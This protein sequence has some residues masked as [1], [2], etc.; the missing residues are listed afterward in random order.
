MAGEN[1]KTCRQ[2]TASVTSTAGGKDVAIEETMVTALYDERNMSLVEDFLFWKKAIAFSFFISLAVIMEGYDTSLMNNFFPFPAFKNKFGDEVDPDGGRL[3]SARWQTIILNGT[4]VGCIIG[5]AINGYLSEWLGYK[6]T[7]VATMMAMVAAIFIP[8]F[9]TS[10]DMYLIGGIIQGLPWGVF[11]TLAVSYAADLCPTH[12][13]AYMTSWVN[14]CWV[15]GGLLSTGILRGLLNIDSEWGYRI[16]FALQWLWPIPVTIATL[17]C[18]ESPWW[19][20]RKG[21]IDE[22]KAAIRM[23]TS[24]R[25]GSMDFDVDSHVEM[26]IVTDKF[27]RQ[28]QA[29]TNYWH[30]FQKS[31]LRRTEIAAMVCITQAFCGVPFMGYGVQF[32]VRAGLD[33][34]SA[35]NLNVVQSCVGLIGCILAWWLMTYFGRRFLY[36]S[37]LSSMFVILMAI[38]F[39]GL[40]PDSNAGTSWAV[41]A[42]IIFMLFLFQ[43][44]LGPICYAVFAEIASTRLRIKTVVIARASYNSAVFVNNAIMPRIVGRNDWDW[45]AKGGFFWAGIDL[46][47]LFWTWFRL[48][49]S[50]GLTYAELDLLFEHEVPARHFSQERADM[51]KPALDEIAAKEKRHSRIQTVEITI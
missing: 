19:L 46:L 36:L 25:P 13:R 1:V 22:A 8:F 5:L 6:K 2:T 10:L 16:P 40:A 45:G 35:F 18:P 47:F 24:P 27:E 20:V 33:T 37:G 44:S 21:R 26:M 9:S 7:M 23:L 50:R 43:L 15:V 11:Q 48:P 39:L 3:V 41:G 34:N 38:G 14:I 32:M 30:C 51:L 29:G 4:Q 12:L 31:D 42:L 17:M 49:E 28:A